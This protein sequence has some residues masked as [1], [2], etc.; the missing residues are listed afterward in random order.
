MADFSE[1]IAGKDAMVNLTVRDTVNVHLAPG[2]L[3]SFQDNVDMSIM[4]TV[5]ALKK[6]IML[7]INRDSDNKYAEGT[8][9]LDKGV[10]KA[11]IDNEDWE[12]YRIYAQA[13]SIQVKGWKHYTGKQPH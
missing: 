2:A 12:Y 3:I 10:S 4:T 11:E 1:I 7:V 9:F 5:D 6:P 8:L 13:N